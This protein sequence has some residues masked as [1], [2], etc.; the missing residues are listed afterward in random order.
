MLSATLFLRCEQGIVF[1]TVYRGSLGGNIV[2]NL[3]TKV[4]VSCM[5]KFPV[6]VFIAWGLWLK[7]QGLA[8]VKD[9]D[10]HVFIP[11]NLKMGC[12]LL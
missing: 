3:C 12:N 9:S 8:A 6:V 1:L 11:Y 2:V 7:P 5:V 10:V 4:V